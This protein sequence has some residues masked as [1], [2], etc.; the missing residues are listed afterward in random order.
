MFNTTEATTCHLKA[1]STK[2]KTGC[3]YRPP[4]AP[5][6]YIERIRKYILS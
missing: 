6:V 5:D 2:M 3:M 1:G 4:N